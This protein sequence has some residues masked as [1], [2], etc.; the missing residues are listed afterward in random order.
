MTDNP[1]Q[2]ATRTWVEAI[3]KYYERSKDRNEL[4]QIYMRGYFAGWSERQIAELADN[5][6][7]NE[8]EYPLGKDLNK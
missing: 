4:T 5:L 2:S 3:Q 6:A 7:K 8:I 1:L